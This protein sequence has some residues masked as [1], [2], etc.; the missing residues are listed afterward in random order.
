MSGWSC[1]WDGCNQPAVQR[2]GDCPLCL[3]HLCR[4]H[5]QHQWHKC[6]RPEDNWEDYCAQIVAT[7]TRQMNGLYHRI[8]NS[9]LCE[10][11]S[12]L[13]MG[14]PC[15]SNLSSK[16]L[17]SMMGGQNCHAEITFQDN[18]KWLARFRLPNI[19]SPPLTTRD[20][21]LQSEAAT[22]I[23]LRNIQ[24]SPCQRSTESPLDWQQASGPQR[25]KIMQQLAD[26][27]LEI[28][29]HPF[30]KIGSIMPDQGP[31]SAFK[32]QGLAHSATFR[33]GNGGPLGPFDSCLE[34]ARAIIETYLSL[35]AN[36]EIA[37]EYPVDICLAHRFRLD[38]LDHFGKDIVSE[39]GFF[40][41]HP[42]DKGDHILINKDYDIVGII[43]W[44][45][46]STVSKEDAFSSPCMMW[47]VTEFYDGCNELACEEVRFAD[48]LRGRG[49]SDLTDCIMKG[50]KVQR[51]FFALGA[52]GEAQG[53]HKTFVNLFLGLRRAFGQKEE[54]WEEWKT[55]ALEK[56]KDEESLHAVVHGNGS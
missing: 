8:D 31:S 19:S 24:P 13:R 35:I 42:D 49:R 48:I 47:P 6:P 53:D 46:C 27:F 29:K 3:R 55:K 41:K 2:A 11:A 26:I 25:E 21:I 17:S 44:E 50:R 40:L 45:W 1:D 15:T 5:L 54:E 18:I 23:F 14:I 28:E 36:G 4:S 56:W 43:D 10:G 9:K 39:G 20:Y 38:I 32:V 22:W 52:A 30:G 33:P 34:A 51:L 16:N 37:G 12:L 7:E